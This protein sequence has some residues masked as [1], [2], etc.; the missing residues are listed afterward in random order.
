MTTPPSPSPSADLP[1]DA[2]TE[3]LL[4]A[5]LDGSLSPPDRQAFEA[6]A[7]VEPAL[8][9]ELA[10]QRRADDSL[11]RQFQPPTAMPVPAASSKGPIAGRIQPA[12]PRRTNVRT[13]AAAAALL[14]AGAGVYWAFNG[15]PFGPPEGMIT[16]QVAYQRVIDGGF[17]P[18]WVCENAEQVAQYTRERFGAPWS[19]DAAPGLT[20]VGWKYS[21][22]LLSPDA[23]MLLATK[24]Q[25]KVV[26]VADRKVHDRGLSTPLLS[27]LRVHKRETADLVLYEISRLPEPA[28][29]N[30]VHVAPA[31]APTPPR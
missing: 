13:L 12:S 16:A 27:G 26:V 3:V 28:V 23:T 31:G 19:I 2:A 25:E 11:R 21:H 8:A 5:Y 22:D 24:D 17:K 9:R 30:H 18:E 4:D 1:L 15:S 29:L 7:A 6:R 10:L 20:L 14:I